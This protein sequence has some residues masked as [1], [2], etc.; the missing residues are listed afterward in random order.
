M[1]WLIA[2]ATGKT[3][4]QTQADDSRILNTMPYCL[5]KQKSHKKEEELRE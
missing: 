5:S 1:E 3:K 2:Q 4:S